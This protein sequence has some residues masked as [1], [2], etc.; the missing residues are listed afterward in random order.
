MTSDE[1]LELFD[2]YLSRRLSFERM[3]LT[4]I[5][6][7]DKDGEKARPYRIRNELLEDIIHDFDILVKSDG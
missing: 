4:V 2:K 7:G 5:E 1:K 3:M 6:Q